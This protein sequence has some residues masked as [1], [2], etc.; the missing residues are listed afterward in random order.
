VE[1]E[2]EEAVAEVAVEE[3]WR[4]RERRERWKDSVAAKEVVRRGVEEGLKEVTGVASATRARNSF[5]VCY[6]LMYV[7]VEEGNNN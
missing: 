6:R 1:E 4:R 5:M 3:A 2:V 7:F